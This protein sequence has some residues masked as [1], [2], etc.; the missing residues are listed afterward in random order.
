MVREVGRWRALANA[1][2]VLAILALAGFGV[3]QVAGRQ[4]RLVFRI[5][6]RLRALVRA[7]ATARIVS[8]GVVGA[9]VVEIVPGRPEAP[10]LG[11]WGVIAAERPVEVGDL[12][13]QA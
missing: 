4:V 8:E 6:A 5:D 13:A 12:L 3:V 2:F 11:E 10:P 7:D 9:K 1:G